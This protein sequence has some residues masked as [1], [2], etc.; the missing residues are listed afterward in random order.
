MHFNI[1]RDQETLKIF[2]DPYQVQN[3]GRSFWPEDGSFSFRFAPWG[4]VCII[5]LNHLPD[6]WTVP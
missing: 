1:V 5:L 4:D 3:K 2:P 6:N